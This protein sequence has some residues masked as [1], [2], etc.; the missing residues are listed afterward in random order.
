MSAAAF[1]QIS[2]DPESERLLERLTELWEPEVLLHKIAQF[3]KGEGHKIVSTIRRRSFKGRRG[4]SKLSRALTSQSLMVNGVPAVRVGVF[5]GPALAYAG[6]TEHGTKKWNPLSP[7]PVIVPKKASPSA[8]AIPTEQGGALDASGDQIFSGPRQQP[9]LKYV[10]LH[11]R[12]PVVGLI[13]RTKRTREA[14]S[15]GSLN[16]VWIL[17]TSANRKPKFY[18]KGGMEEYLPILVMRLADFI[19]GSLS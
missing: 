11:G 7:Y 19:Q 6:I 2:L 8:L 5:E 17:V 18:L 16:I 4:V 13:V 1:V 15:L 12:H 14:L 3:F 10:R 9:Q